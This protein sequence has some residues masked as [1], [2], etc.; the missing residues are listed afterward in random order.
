MDF[1]FFLRRVR[2]KGV[3]LV[4]EVAGDWGGVGVFFEAWS[5]QGGRFG[6]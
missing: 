5:G 6:P 1:G 3:V 2:V 4:R